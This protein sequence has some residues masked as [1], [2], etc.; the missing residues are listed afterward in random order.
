MSVARE[1]DRDE[2]AQVH[3]RCWYP[4]LL[5]LSHTLIVLIVSPDSRKLTPRLL[6]SYPTI[7]LEVVPIC[8]PSV[9]R[10]LKSLGSPAPFLRLG[11]KAKAGPIVTDNGNFII[12][13]PFAPLRL[14]SDSEGD[15]DGKWSVV[16]LARRL[17]LIVGV[18]ETGLFTG[19]DGDEVAEAVKAG[20][21]GEGEGGGQKPIAAYFGTEGGEVVVRK[22]ARAS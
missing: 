9:L 12:D 10:A 16:D 3:L 1:A 14:A 2:L 18:V 5:S 15:S 17:K 6:T 11:G 20:T 7:P 21:E 19:R 4:P 22:A 8:A 13:A